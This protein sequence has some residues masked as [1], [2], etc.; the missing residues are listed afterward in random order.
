MRER[1]ETGVWMLVTFGLGAFFAW[2]WH[3]STSATSLW[4]MITLVAGIGCAIGV[5]RGA[6]LFLSGLSGFGRNFFEDREPPGEDDT[7]DS[8]TAAP[9][10]PPTLLMISGIIA[11]LL[12]FFPALN[13]AQEF[14]PDH[15]VSPRVLVPWMFIAGFLMVT[16]CTALLI[17]L[18]TGPDR[19]AFVSG[20][21]EDIRKTSRILAA[22]G[23]LL[24]AIAATFAI[25]GNQQPRADDGTLAEH[26]ELGSNRASEPCPGVLVA[27]TTVVRLGA[28]SGTEYSPTFAFAPSGEVLIIRAHIQNQ[29]RRQRDHQFSTLR[30]AHVQAGGRR[31]ESH[32]LHNR[33]EC[34]RLGHERCRTIAEGGT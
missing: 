18:K 1:V 7:V 34:A 29:V 23:V 4:W 28:Y 32:R 20:T 27:D 8:Q 6:Q 15:W 12:R 3:S 16:W 14:S 10:L 9:L 2:W 11:G 5:A 33:G 17:M 31:F 24:M 25:V 21:R 13:S 22:I 26:F 30:T 19:W